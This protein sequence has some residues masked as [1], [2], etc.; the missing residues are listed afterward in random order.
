V[1]TAD[2]RDAQVPAEHAITRLVLDAKIPPQDK[3]DVARGLGDEIGRQHGQVP[4]LHPA[5]ATLPPGTAQLPATT[6]LEQDLDG[7]LER[8]ASLAFRT[9]FLIGAGLALAALASLLW[10]RRT[11]TP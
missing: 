7:Q 10:Q 9:S 8:A 5:F 4:D 2:L 1:F 3:V 11:E 6:Q